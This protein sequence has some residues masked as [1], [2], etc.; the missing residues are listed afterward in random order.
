MGVGIFKYSLILVVFLTFTSTANSQI[1]M[2]VEYFPERLS[3]ESDGPSSFMSRNAGLISVTS[4]F[5]LKN[6][7]LEFIPYIGV[8]GA[9]GNYTLNGTETNINSSGIAIGSK[10]LAYPLDFLNDCDCPTFNKSGMWFKK[11]FFFFIDPQFLTYN[12]TI[13]SELVS[14]EA[15]R[16]NNLGMSIGLGIDFGLSAGFTLTPYAA[17]HTQLASISDNQFVLNTSG[18]SIPLES[19]GSR[20]SNPLL[21]GILLQ[22]RLV[23]RRY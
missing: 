11:G 4:Y 13:D 5:R 2:S 3:L 12:Y 17:Y 16:F 20:R 14:I 22:Y 7:R 18:G 23:K 1:G 9:L 8:F 10:I 6:I 15:D 19:F 21:V